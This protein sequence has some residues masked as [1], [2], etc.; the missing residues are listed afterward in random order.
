MLAVGLDIKLRDIFT[1]KLQTNYGLISFQDGE[2][3]VRGHFL[4]E[5]RRIAR[6]IEYCRHWDQSRQE[7]IIYVTC[8]VLFPHPLAPTNAT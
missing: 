4:Q 7:D 5:D 6:S 8:V 2:N 1:V 3:H